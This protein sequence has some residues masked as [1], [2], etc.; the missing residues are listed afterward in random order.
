MKFS[1]SAIIGAAISVAVFS[2]S[3]AQA[4][5][6]ECQQNVSRA[7]ADKYEILSN[8][9]YTH[10][11]DNI[12]KSVFWGVPQGSYSK[13]EGESSLVTLKTAV[14]EARKAWNTKIYTNVFDSIFK[15]EPKFK[16]DCNHP[17]RVIQPPLGVWWKPEDCH[18]MDYICGNPP[19]ICHFMPMIKK[20][21]RDKFIQMLQAS[22]DGD[23][24][25]VYA[26][27]IGPALD[28]V[29]TDHAK[30]AQFKPTLHANLNQIL[31]G[32]RGTFFGFADDKTWERKWDDEIKAM[33][34]TFP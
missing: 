30:L 8:M 28:K 31:E 22:V 21:I 33:L 1:L 5:E 18:Q 3:V 25:D 11:G 29:T 17:K 24:S 23:E 9:Y 20:R 15:D 2:P 10:L 7:F 32:L 26:N 27:Y 19:S 14:D 13:A 12:E 16:G 34:L 4:C 6:R